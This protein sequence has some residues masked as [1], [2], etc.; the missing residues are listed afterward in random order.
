MIT[1][2]MF[3]GN[4]SISKQ[5]IIFSF[6]AVFELF[7]FRASAQFTVSGSAGGTKDG[8]Y[9]TLTGAGTAPNA[10]GGVFAA[11]NSVA[12]TGATITVSVT[13]NSTAEPG[14]NS[15]GAGAWAS[16]TI[17][18]SGG[19]SRTISGSVAAPLIDLSG[20]D[21]VTFNGL[22]TGGNSLTI[23][24]TNTGTTSTTSTFRFIGDATNNTITNCSVQGSATMAVTTNGGTIFFSTSTTNGND[25]NTISNCDIGPAGANLPSKAIYGNGSTTSVTRANS[26]IS[27]TNCNI[28][29]FFLNGGSNAGIYANDGNTDWSI[30][31][32][33]FYQTATRTF[34]SG[35]THS[36]IFLNGT[37]TANNNNIITGNIF[38]FSSS[39]G[40]GTYTI[41]G[42]STSVFIPINLAA[43]G[44]TTATSIQNN[45]IS[46]ISFTGAMS[47]TSSSAPFRGIYV[48]TGLTT[49][50]NISGNT[51]GSMSATGNISYS[52]S[53][54]STSDVIG[55]FNFGSSNWTTTN[56]NIGGITAANTSTGAANVYALRCNTSSS[57]TWSCVGNNIGG[58]VSNS[59]QSTSTSTSSVVNGILN[60]NPIG[61]FTSNII[62]NLS[63][64]AGTGTTTSA[65]VIGI[66]ISASSANQTLSQNTIFN[67]SNTNA[68]AASVVTG[69]QF[70]G[71]T[72]NIVER[73]SIYALTAATT[74]TSA[75][76]NG[77][78]VAGGTTTYRNN[79]IALGA[80][81]TNAIG[82]AATNSS[83]VGING[84]NGALGTDNFWHNSVY[85]GGSPT[86]GSGS[87]YAFNGTQTTNTRSFRDNIFVNARANSGATGKNYAIKINGTAPN[88]TGL[89][90]NNNVYFVSGS[91]TVFGFFNSAD[92]ANLGAWKTA[93]GQDAASFESNPQY[94][95]PTNATPDL[96]IHPTN[97]TFVESGGVD[98]GVTLDYDGATRAGLTPV[99]IGADAGNFTSAGDIIAPSITY[100]VLS[101]TLC[102]TDRTISATI[103]DVSGIN[104]T[105]GTKPRLYFKKSTDANTYAGNT[106]VDNG[107][108]YVEATNASSPFSFTT[109]Y[110]LLQSAVVTS[111][112]IQYFI[113]AQDLAGTP[114][115]GINSGTFAAQ[116]TSVALTS[117]AFALTGT[118][119]S[120]TILSGGLSGTVTIGAAGTYTSLT[121]AGGLFSAINSGG[122]SANLTANIIDASVT[123]TGAT[124]LNAIS[125]G[126]ATYTLT[127]KP[128][129]TATLTGSV[130]AGAIIKLN[131]ADN[132]II[133]GSN[134]GGTDRSLTITNTN[135]SGSSGVVWIASASGTDGAT[136]NTVKNCI[137]TGNS[138]TTTFAGIFIGG[139]S[140]IGTSS[141]AAFPNTGN[142]IQN[143]SIG[144][145]Q[146]G[147]ITLG[148]ST[149]GYNTGNIITKNLM[150]GTGAASLKLGGILARF[151]SGISITE[152]T[153]ANISNSTSIYGISLGVNSFN[154]YSPGTS[155]EVVG[156]TISKNAISSLANSGNS[157]AFG[158]VVCP[159]TSG[160]T[161]ISNNTIA[162]VTSAATPSD[163]TAGIYAGGGAGS[164]T[165]IYFNSISMTGS[166]GR[167]TPSHA[168][169]IGGSNPVVDIKNNILYNTSTGAGSYAFC[170]AYSTF[171]NLTFNYNSLFT[172]GANSLFAGTGSISAPTAQAN[173][174]TLNATISGGANS[175]SSDPLYNSTTNLQ[176][177]TGSPVLAA[178]ITIGGVSTDIQ[179]VTR[180]GSPSIGAYENGLDALAPTITYT[181]LGITCSLSNR[182]VSAT[183]TD[184]SGIN[185]TSGTKPRIYFKKSTNSNSLGATNDNTTDGWK[186]T[187][188]TNGS[189]PFTIDIDYSLVFGGVTAGETI[190]YFVVAQDLASTPNVGINSGIFA[191]NPSSV[192]LTGA[193]FALTG[194]I[195]SYSIN[196]NLTGS[197]TV[198]SA[199]SAPFNSLTNA[200]AA[201]NSGCLSSAV[202]FNLED[203]TYSGSETFPIT[204]NQNSFASATN[205]LTIRPANSTAVTIVG[206]NSTSI[207]NINGGDYIILDG[208]NSGGASMLL[209][210]TNTSGS[211]VRFIADATNNTIQNSTIEGATTSS[212]SGVVLISTGTTTGNDNLSINNNTIRDRSDAAGVPANLLYGAGSSSTISNGT[213]SIANNQMFNFTGLGIACIGTGSSNGMDNVTI[214]GNTIFEGAVRS[215]ALTGISFSA[216]GT[217]TI[218]DN[219]IRDLN[220]SLAVTGM[221]FN[222]CRNTTVSKNRIYSIPSTSGSTGTLIGITYSGSSGNPAS[223][224]LTN[225]YVSI[226]PSFT[227]AQVIQAFR[228]FGFSGNTFNA[229]YNTVYVGGT[230]SGTSNS[231]ALYRAFSAPT[232]STMKNNI[233]FNDR[234]GGTGNHFA[235]GDQSANTGTYVGDYNLYVG[236]GATAANFMDYGSSSSGTPVSFTTWKTGPPTRDANSTGSTRA[237]YTAASTV[238]TDLTPASTDLHIR[239]DRN[240]ALDNTGN[241]NGILL[242]DDFDATSVRSIVTPFT[243]DIGADEWTSTFAVS[244]GVDQT[245]GCNATT[246]AGSAVPSGGTGLW[247]VST[248]SA[249]FGASG[250]PTST[251]TALGVGVNT[252]TWTVTAGSCSANDNV[253][254]SATAGSSWIGG[255]TTD[256][257]TSSNWCGGVPTITSDVLIANGTSPYPVIATGAQVANA[258]DIG[259]TASLD[260][261]GGSLTPNQNITNNGTLTIGASGT[262]DM[263]SNQVLGTGTVV[264]NGTLQTSKAA[265]FSGSASTTIV[266][267]ITTLTLGSASTIDY[268]SI[269]SQTITSGN[270]SNLSNSGNGDR[271][272]DNAGT[273]GVSSVLS[274]GTGNYTIGTSTVEF[275]G[276]SPQSIPAL[277]VVSG[278]NYNN[279][280][281]NNSAGATLS[282][283]V[284]LKDALTLTSGAFDVNGNTLTLLSTLSQTARIAPVT[285]GSFVGS[286]TMQRFVPGAVGGWATIG[287]PVTGATIAEWN[288]DI[289]ITGINGGASGTGS[290]ISI[291]S[292]DETV[293]GNADN[294]ASY[295]AATDVTNTVDPKKGYF[296]YIAD[297]ATQVSDKLIDVVGPPLVGSQNLNVSFTANTS[298]AEDGWN[299][300]SNP[301]CSAI[302]WLAGGWTKTNM[303]DAIYIYNADNVQYVGSVGGIS[304]NGGNE[305]IG[306]SQAFMVHANAASPSLIAAESVKSASNPTF[307]KSNNSTPAGVLRLQLDGLNGLYFDETVFRTTVG[308]TANFDAAL[309]AYKLYSFDPAAPNISSK[310]NGIEYVVNAVPEINNNLDIP[311]R[312][313]VNTPGSYTINFKGLQN[314][315]TINCF[316]FEDKLTNTSIDLKLD[317]TYTF[318]SIV[319]T[320]SAYSRFVLHFGVEAIVPSISASATTLGYP[321]NST[322][323]YANSTTGAVAYTWN[324]G[325]GTALETSANPSHTYTAPGVYTVSFTALN[326][327][328]CSETI[329]QVITVENV[330]SVA[331]INQNESVVITQSPEGLVV[332][333]SFKNS[334]KLAVT[335]YN[336][337]G[338]KVTESE[339]KL[340]QDKGQFILQ[341]GQLAKGIYTVES[342]YNNNKKVQKIS[343]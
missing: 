123:E 309:D 300:I 109:D 269:G 40:T 76:I 215:T 207:I 214:S 31:N 130:A 27:I 125:Y 190:Q 265:G 140:S 82:A 35:G 147:I 188:A 339:Q 281:L 127:I 191:A 247:T 137:L 267:T 176:P 32:N 306:S 38:G 261:N 286:L 54:S 184:A 194:S 293:T 211:T 103:T 36:C 42:I 212:T 117:A 146:Y 3:N 173:L 47:G 148:V 319:D 231:W 139:T 132:V 104:T 295:I 90:I 100:T 189:S 227:N 276:T 337:L 208:I 228:D 119:N 259:S 283:N 322:V 273:I 334:T 106:S 288:D 263:V 298:A 138:N 155:N 179:G 96:H 340:L 296:V 143:N 160:T 41:V 197:Y 278:A 108:K 202:V 25:N 118:I 244:A 116:P 6:I 21:N 166:T 266:N 26:G 219:T 97:P 58:S 280:T 128:N 49:I 52:S 94:L 187:E 234:T 59:I 297:N 292:Y 4:G 195:N 165:Q 113:V 229:Y 111:D 13:A 235:G 250:S 93:V 161:S 321:G 301:Y 335:L 65:S 50:G 88:P 12:Q 7:S 277:P 141:F 303:D 69:I 205:T 240:C 133:D 186:Y 268:S 156:A 253:D 213:I 274:S 310:V 342:I 255:G 182:T 1:T 242:A 203:A 68:T 224:T 63:A 285:G 171:T 64:A 16:I 60:S 157:S 196:N 136:T 175:I 271:V 46:N 270:Y 256:W 336:S 260:V 193:A 180:G 57:A 53:S 92:V 192:A 237:S 324:F 15:L 114:N 2:K 87:S 272:L 73:N 112:V 177:S 218:T 163:F 331:G 287:M 178:G 79:M 78:R 39:G 10:G 239:V 23:A 174:A 142:T 67:L 62:K 198:G 318:T 149:S 328:G 81:V 18:P 89:T 44:T 75:E 131:G 226:I 159:A 151:E 233:S 216:T 98:L 209:R 201:Y 144:T 152:N 299:L 43:V 232:T 323:T 107:W 66:C 249:T 304:Y 120:F 134:S 332:N 245:L 257:L 129:T 333:Y 327:A 164:T 264:I 170:T 101:N 169:A 5:L 311:V 294:A 154:T 11:L 217:N 308:A 312:V 329:S 221:L 338:E 74:S 258:I 313:N 153:I 246:L 343:F 167:T 206:S 99:D 70:T 48:G 220:T 28:F 85:I 275:N 91:G 314:F 37:S 20:A 326:A 251:V 243:T 83:T 126:C 241:N 135:T 71:S 223:I 30:T 110:S 122:L 95:D 284:D 341:K 150:N 222:D 252:L 238:F 315:A 320:N 183:I 145:T 56:N 34:S 181:A 254:V 204:I 121:G 168:L 19:A 33:K 80:G 24:N 102:T 105:G 172:S 77:I 282:A 84:I 17:S 55:I 210:N 230:A 302:D 325:D 248:G 86:S 158:I 307:Y 316:T 61:T 305:I 45:T 330:T 289:T 115:V 14:T 317:S 199:Q 124:A 236:T 29:N 8:T 162:A 225:N 290:F 262:L 9:A 200:V 185:T 279:L 291:Y 72:A 22:N 51:I